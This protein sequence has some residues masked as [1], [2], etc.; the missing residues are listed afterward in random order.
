MTEDYDNKVSKLLNN[1][2]DEIDERN[3]INSNNKA[4]KVCIISQLRLTLYKI[5]IM[6]MY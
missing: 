4:L 3:I 2:T 1:F 6:T 5:R